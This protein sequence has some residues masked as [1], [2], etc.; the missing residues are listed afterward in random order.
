MSKSGCFFITCANY[1]CWSVSVGVYCM[2]A[3][4]EWGDEPQ[5]KSFF[6]RCSCA[7]IHFAQTQVVLK[8]FEYKPLFKSLKLPVILMLFFFPSMAYSDTKCI[9]YVLN[10]RYFRYV[11]FNYNTVNAHIKWKC[12][13]STT[14]YCISFYFFV[15]FV[16]FFCRAAF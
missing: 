2:P 11:L 3:S 1:A 5:F 9:I 13:Y 12:I 8:Y 6:Y 7:A 4:L 15:W 16:V 10:S 14:L